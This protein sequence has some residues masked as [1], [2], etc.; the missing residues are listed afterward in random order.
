MTD[1]M[2][3]SA[4]SSILFIPFL[5]KRKNETRKIKS[6]L[7]PSLEYISSMHYRSAKMIFFDDGMILFENCFFVAIGF[8]LFES[9]PCQK[10]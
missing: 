4:W 1:E 9:L 2:T 10:A 8:N 6:K 7:N 3:E 5:F